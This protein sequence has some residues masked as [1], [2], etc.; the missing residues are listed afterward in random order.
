MKPDQAIIKA[1]LNLS[2]MQHDPNVSTA[3]RAIGE[4]CSTVVM[5]LITA[6]SNSNAY[7]QAKQSLLERGRNARRQQTESSNDP[8]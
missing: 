3:S 1:V 2:N 5:P 4:F 8:R 7:K 6:R